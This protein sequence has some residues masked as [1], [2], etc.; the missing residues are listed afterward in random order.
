MNSESIITSGEELNGGNGGSGL[1]NNVNYKPPKTLTRKT[2]RLIFYTLMIA[3]P[4]INFL[5]FYVYVN[6]DSIL[7]AFQRYQYKTNGEMGFDVSFTLDNFRVVYEYINRSD[8]WYMIGNSL[9]LY[10][11][12]LF[13]G[14]GFALVFSYYVYKKFM[15]AGVFRVL[16]Y[17][18]SIISGVVMAMIY[19]YI[20]K[21]VLPGL[22]NGKIG[23]LLDTADGAFPALLGYTIFFS[24][25]V[26]VLMYTGSMSGINE[27]VVESAHLD[28]AN[29]VQEFI[30]ITIPM[31]WPTMI[32]FIVSGIA[33]MF[34]DQ[35]GL[36][37]FFKDVAP[38]GVST[39][40][41]FIY[42]RTLHA[43][44]VGDP[45]AYINLNN[46]DIKISLLSYPQLSALGLVITAFTLPLALFAKW[47]MTKFG[48]SAD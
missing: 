14:T 44:M 15:F 40:G 38:P 36:Y 48:P 5:V 3:I 32:T 25:G 18:P 24:F 35:M 33:A 45:N 29:V 41:Y 30:H 19:T 9:T 28:G 22:S 47:A 46:P 34:T 20:L 21:D 4:F 7:M 23:Y 11:I 17:L 8:Y 26:N 12:K 10:V 16:L 37:T 43:D 42:T 1:P 39:V 31:I 6:I 27:S 13:F 2:K